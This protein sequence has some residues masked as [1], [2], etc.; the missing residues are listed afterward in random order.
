MAEFPNSITADGLWTLKKVRKA[1]LG[2][3]WPRM[4]INIEYLIVAGGGGGGGEHGGG[5]GAG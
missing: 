4:P 2:S 5:G 1:I 3:T